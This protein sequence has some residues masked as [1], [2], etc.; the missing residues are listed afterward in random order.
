MIAITITIID[1]R[2][3]NIESDDSHFLYHFCDAWRGSSGSGVYSWQYNENAGK[4]ERRLIGIFTGNRWKSDDE[5]F[6]TA[7][8][9]NA[10]VKITPSKYVQLCKWLGKYGKKLCDYSKTG[11]VEPRLYQ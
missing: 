4:W 6:L 10:A 3:C 11:K 2:S 9:F 8:N 7:K 1:F 5:W